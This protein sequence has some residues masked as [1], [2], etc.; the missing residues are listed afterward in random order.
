MI[1][2]GLDEEEIARR[3]RLYIIK[4]LGEFQRSYHRRRKSR[5]NQRNHYVPLAYFVHS[6]I[7]NNE[8]L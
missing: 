7:L 2:Q 8:N 5:F 1:K 4:Q 6:E 3:N